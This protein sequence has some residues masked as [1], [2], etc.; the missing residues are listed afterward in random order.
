M[1]FIDL[2]G[3]T[4]GQWKVIR[5]VKGQAQWECHCA[6]GTVG[7]I[8]AG[9]LQRGTSTRCVKCRGLISQTHNRKHGH[10]TRKFGLSSEYNSWKHVKARCES[11]SDPAWPEYGGAGVMLYK[12]WSESAKA[13]LDYMGRKPTP[14]HTVDRFPDPDGNYEPGNVRWATKQEQANNRRSNLIVTIDGVTGTLRQLSDRFGLDYDFMR[15]RVQQREGYRKT[16]QE[17][18]DAYRLLHS[19]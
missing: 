3:Q 9:H 14:K 2:T 11:T 12:P 13:F 7:F 17:S 16:A 5:Y 6:C 8:R 4:F 15:S 19:V 18:A 1:K 10:S